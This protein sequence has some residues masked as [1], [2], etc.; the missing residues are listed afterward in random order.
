MNHARLTGVASCSAAAC[1]NAGGI[2]GSARNEYGTWA[3][4]D[5]HAQAYSVLFDERSRRI[6]NNLDPKLN[7]HENTLCLKC[8]V[9]QDHET[10]RL[11]PGFE[12]AD[13]VHC[14]NC[15]GAAQ[16]WLTQHYLPGWGVASDAA[17]SRWGFKNTKSLLV[18]AQSCVEC[19]VGSPRTG[20]DVNH[21]LIA[22]GHPRLNFE[23]SNHLA[24]YPRHWSLSAD[25][26]RYPDFEA[27]AWA[28]GQVVS[29][30]QALVLLAWRAEHAPWPEL[31]EYNCFAC[32]QALRSE[33][34]RNQPHSPERPLGRPG[35][36][37]WYL[38]L[39][40]KLDG[41]EELGLGRLQ[42]LMGA[43][44]SKPEKVVQEARAV[45]GRL[46]TMIDIL[47][48]YPLTAAETQ[49][50]LFSITQDKPS[51][52]AATWDDAAQRYLALTALHQAL[53]DLRP[54]DARRTQLR[55]GLER[56]RES[57]QFDKGY[58]SPK[59]GFDPAR[60]IK[61]WESLE[62]QPGP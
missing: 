30:K 3:S 35:W 16:G 52:A 24:L 61:L 18:R 14:E 49:A 29:A 11:S 47:D 10:E 60:V 4:H 9:S 55:H 40:P 27:R 59:R 13:G 39:L 53:D 43:L 17:K 51:A 7:A 20:A 56:L 28:I 8:H 26:Q 34:R 15:H 58:D 33:T 57:L 44:G 21:D 45:A 50:V 32:H 12:V 41:D 36:N 46:D 62:Q 38:G 19:H 2:Q 48:R 22:A 25:K 23:F 6:Q 42:E 37:R 54:T 31:A 5:R 1:H